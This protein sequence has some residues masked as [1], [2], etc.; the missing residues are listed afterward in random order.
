MNKLFSIEQKKDCLLT[1][2]ESLALQETTW[3]RKRSTKQAGL[4]KVEKIGSRRE[5]N[6]QVTKQEHEQTKENNHR[7]KMTKFQNTKHFL[8]NLAKFQEGMNCNWTGTLVTK[9]TRTA[10]YEPLLEETHSVTMTDPALWKVR[11]PSFCRTSG[12]IF[13]DFFVKTMK[14]SWETQD[15]ITD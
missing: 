6:L 1:T 4:E 14:K 5:L 8:E 2:F 13:H 7:R 12:K 3:S 10:N 11:T 15:P 9:V